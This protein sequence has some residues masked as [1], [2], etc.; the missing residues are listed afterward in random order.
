[1]INVGQKNRCP[2]FTHASL[3]G[4]GSKQDLEASSVKVVDARS[5][6]LITIGMAGNLLCLCTTNKKKI[7]VFELNPKKLQSSKLKVEPS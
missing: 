4:P 2:C 5:C 6:Q 7:S 1:M 3:L